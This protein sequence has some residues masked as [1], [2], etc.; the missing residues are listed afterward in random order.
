MICDFFLFRKVF[1]VERVWSESWKKTKTVLIWRVFVVKTKTIFNHR[2]RVVVVINV[3]HDIDATLCEL[4]FVWMRYL[5]MQRNECKDQT[6]QILNE[7][8]EDTKSFRIFTL[9]N[10]NQRPDFGSLQLN[11]MKSIHFSFVATHTSNV[12]RSGESEHT[13]KEMCSLFITISSSCFPIRSGTGQFLSLCLEN[14][15][16][17]C[18]RWCI[19]L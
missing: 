19:S 13:A 12:K 17:R 1:T 14:S 2:I 8:V 3:V 15:T 7:V 6:L 10:V 9:L 18:E 16:E 11:R 4:W 5:E